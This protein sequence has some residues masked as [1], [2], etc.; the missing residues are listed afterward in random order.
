V[1]N[2][3]SCNKT[4]YLHNIRLPCNVEHQSTSPPKYLNIHTDHIQAI[5]YTYATNSNFTVTHTLQNY[6]CDAYDKSYYIVY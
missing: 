1:T 2:H 4:F 6:E 3:L 5:N